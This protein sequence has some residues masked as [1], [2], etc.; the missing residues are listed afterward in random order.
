MIVHT[1]DKVVNVSLFIRRGDFAHG[2][3]SV[4]AGWYFVVAYEF[5]N[6]A[7]HGSPY[8]AGRIRIQGTVHMY[9]CTVL[10]TYHFYVTL[11]FQLQ[12]TPLYQL[13]V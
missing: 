2:C 5:T 10:Q 4:E 11:C 13:K 8:V 7:I 6:N 3:V 1:L 12:R 9:T